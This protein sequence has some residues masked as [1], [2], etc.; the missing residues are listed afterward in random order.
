MI[1][2]ENKDGIFGFTAVDNDENIIGFVTACLREIGEPIEGAQWLVPY[3]FVDKEHRRKG[4]GSA[5]L[6]EICVKAREK[7]IIQLGSFWLDEDAV[8]FMYSNNFSLC[9]G[10]IYAGNV[11]P[12]SAA[13]RV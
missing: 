2:D 9:T 6:N 5:L 3:L 1:V 12:I 13:I 11:K 10:Y 8:N 4:I 7:N